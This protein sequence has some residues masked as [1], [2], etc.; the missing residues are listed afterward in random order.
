MAKKSSTR[1]DKVV[2]DAKKNGTAAPTKSVS[3][4][5]AASARKKAEKKPPQVK[6]EYEAA[7]SSNFATAAVC[8][9]LCAL[10]AIMSFNSE[11]ALLRVVKSAILGLIGQ[12]AF[13][14][15][16]PALFYLFVIHL[17][18]RKKRL[19]LRTFCLLSFVFLC[20]CIFHMIVYAP[21]VTEGFQIVTELYRTG[22]LGPLLPPR[23]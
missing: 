18:N 8:F 5:K 19:R 9:F 22:G 21:A 13:Y 1:A 11:G 14:F 20:G 4:R 12:A 16:I 17:F 15:S 2:S 23:L 6:T 3:N 10:F 7:V